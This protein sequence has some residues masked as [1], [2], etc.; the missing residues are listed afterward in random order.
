MKRLIYI[1]SILQL[2][3]VA[4]MGQAHIRFN[5]YWDNVYIINPASINDAHLGSVSMG[6]RQQYHDIPGAP[7]NLMAMGTRYFEDFS[8]QLGAK[9]MTENKGYMNSL[10]MDLSYSV[11]IPLTRWWNLNMG[12]TVSYQNQN[13]DI[14]QITLATDEDLSRF[15]ETLMMTN[16]INSDFG[17]ELNSEN[18]KIGVASHNVVSAFKPENTLHLNTNVIYA[19]YRQNTR[20]FVD[21]AFGVSAF[22]YA[23]VFQVETTASAFI[24]K[25]YNSNPIQI[26]LMYRTWREVGFMFGFQLDQF[27]VSYSYD[28]N[29][30][31]L[32][33]HSY[34]SHEIVLSYTFDRRGACRICW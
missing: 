11:S 10:D 32:M 4:T 18:M 24:Q 27:K 6:M 20:N 17:F 15:N 28:Y 21:Y 25:D 13:F 23:N 8:T 29:F 2:I 33:R 22:Q 19:L 26:G 31:N 7:R 5:N 16:A 34:G 30:G 1:F 3:V 14:S 12:L 9:I